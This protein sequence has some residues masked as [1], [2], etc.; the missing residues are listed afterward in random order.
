MKKIVLL[1]A[2]FIIFTASMAQKGGG[3][4]LTGNIT[5]S[6]NGKPMEYATV[7]LFTQGNKRPVNGTI[8][9]KSGNFTLTDVAEGKY[10]MVVEF[11]GY[12]PF[13]IKEITVTKSGTETDLKNISLSSKT[14]SMEGVTVVAQGKLVENKIDKLVYNAEKDITSQ[15]GVAT[16]ILKKVPQVSVDIDGNVQL[17]GSGG[18]RFLI[19]GKPSTAFGASITDVLQSIPASQIKSIEVITNPGAKYDA[20][21]MGGIINIILKTSKAKGYNGNLS[22][23]VSTRNEN[24]SFNFNVRNNNFGVNAFVGFNKRLKA[25]TTNIY[26]RTSTYGTLVSLLQQQ[27]TGHQERQGVQTGFGFDWTYKK[28]NSFS[29]AFS[30][31][32]FYNRSGV[33]TNQQFVADKSSTQPAVLTTTN[34]SN[35]ATFNNVDASLTYKRTFAKEDRELEIGLNTSAGKSKGRASGQQFTLPQDSLFYGS[36][37]TNPGKEHETEITADYTDPLG[38]DFVLGVGGK[39]VFYNIASNV[40]VLSYKASSQLYVPDTAQNNNL[41]YKQKVYAAYTELSF[42]LAKTI[43]AKIGGRYE[44]TEINT[45]FANAQLQVK[46]PGYNTFVP[47]VFLLKK[48]GEAQ[49]L[50]LSYSKRIERPDYED[51]NP[52]VNISDAKNLSTGNPALKPEIGN[53]IELAYSREFGKLGSMTANLFYRINDNDI[54]P[55]IIYYPTY[56]VGDSVFTNVSVS[57]RQNIGMEKN[58]GLNLFYDLHPNSKLSFRGNVFLFRRHTINTIDKGFN[59]TSFNYRFNINS[60]YQFTPTLVAEFFGNFNSA[61]HEAQ[62]SYPSFTSYSLAVRKQFWNKRGSLALTANNFF[63]AYINQTVTLYGPGLSVN[64]NRKVPFRSI[65]LNFTWKF[66]KL[67]FKKD[68]AE[69]D[70]NLNG[71]VE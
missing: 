41:N 63:N 11:I 32:T 50:K 57:S 38:K 48:I 7:T 44:R 49:T 71:P 24:G 1:I 20:Q 42:P 29:G 17:A 2:C 54:Q 12:K 66:G 47:S 18:V 52:Y 33:F 64:Y 30:Y 9:D 23:T 56:K 13:S 68:K 16:D 53:R 15:S 40:D 5:D 3:V 4:T 26:D 10:R 22:L 36:Q 45:Y 28:L 70:N 43:S 39:A 69:K 35:R 14:G 62:G 37:T 60:T 21:G 55:Y 58:A 19:N 34:T 31:N 25:N 8:S 51:L 67:E 59:T 46:V 61:R 65:G 27:G 6:I